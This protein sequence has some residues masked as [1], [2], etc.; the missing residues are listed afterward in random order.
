MLGLFVCPKEQETLMQVGY[1]S[2][3]RVILGSIITYRV[4]AVFSK[5]DRFKVKA[6]GFGI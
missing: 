1:V 3:Y 2:M 4:Y 5:I 6:L